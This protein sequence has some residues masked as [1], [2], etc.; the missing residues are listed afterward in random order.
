MYGLHVHEAVVAA[1]E[2]ESGVTI[3]YVDNHYDH[4]NIILQGKCPVAPTDTRNRCN[5]TCI[6]LNMSIFQRL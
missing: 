3:H 6:N 2:K 4:G 1:H 5:R